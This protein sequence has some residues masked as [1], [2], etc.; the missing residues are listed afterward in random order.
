MN[1]LGGMVFIVAGIALGY[2]ALTGKAENFLH[3]VNYGG[4]Q[5]GQQ[6]GGFHLSNPIGPPTGNPW[7]GLMGPLS[8][9]FANLSQGAGQVA[10]GVQQLDPQLIAYLNQDLQG[11]IIPGVPQNFPGGTFL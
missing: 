6:Q 9:F 7:A 3:A 11:E 4:Q 8:P 2:W 1:N 10:P 5:Q